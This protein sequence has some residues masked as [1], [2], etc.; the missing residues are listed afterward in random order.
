MAAII[1]S[2]TAMMPLSSSSMSALSLR[3]RLVGDVGDL[4]V[5]AGE[6]EAVGVVGVGEDDELIQ[7]SAPLLIRSA[8]M[9]TALPLTMMRRFV[10][11]F[12]FA[13]RYAIGDADA[14]RV[15]AARARAPCA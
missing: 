1:V 8:G 9:P 5:D 10:T 11:S 6:T 14:E 12:C 7:G 3:A 13:H 15:A 4:D 2:L